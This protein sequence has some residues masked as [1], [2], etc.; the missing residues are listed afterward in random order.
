MED[1]F[2]YT[3]KLFNP[4][5]TNQ[6][7]EVLKGIRV[8]DFS[9]VIFGPTATRIMANYGAE[10]IKLELPFHGDLWRPAT[11]WGKYWKHSNPLWHFVTQ[12]KYFVGLDLKHPEAKDIIYRLAQMCDV[13]A[14][15]FAAGTAEAWGWAT[16]QSARSTPRSS[17]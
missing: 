6:K 8:L 11:Y 7:P 16:R 15:N 4:S 17:I 12:N 5:E 2:S 10:V 14:E 3:A 9:H 13:V 1:Y